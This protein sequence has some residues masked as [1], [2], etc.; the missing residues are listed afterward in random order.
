M[1]H[2]L[3]LLFCCL[4]ISPA[5]AGKDKTLDAWKYYEYRVAGSISSD[6]AKEKLSNMTSK[7]KKAHRNLDRLAY[8]EFAAE[9]FDKLIALS[10]DNGGKKVTKPG[11][12]TH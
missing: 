7:M 8:Y 11:W 1:K 4:I 9:M 12:L 6:A 3:I 2:V 5:H 10:N